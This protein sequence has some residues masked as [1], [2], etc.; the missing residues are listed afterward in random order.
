MFSG[1]SVSTAGRT[2]RQ[3]MTGVEGSMNTSSG[4]LPET[5]IS[6]QSL[7]GVRHRYG[8]NCR[9]NPAIAL[10]RFGR[11]DDS[12]YFFS[13]RRFFLCLSASSR[14]C[15]CVLVMPLALRSRRT[16]KLAGQSR[17]YRAPFKP[18][19]A[20]IL[21]AHSSISRR[22]RPPVLGDSS[23]RLSRFPKFLVLV[24]LGTSPS[25]GI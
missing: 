7:K 15:D 14:A 9:I 25:I 13:R 1:R 3:S 20:P 4:P 2:M 6:A 24:P 10:P 22:T 23:Q 11:E 17:F 12:L 21:C 5:S 18:M 8:E 19:I 16:N